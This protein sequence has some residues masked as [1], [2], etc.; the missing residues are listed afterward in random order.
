MIASNKTLV[1]YAKNSGYSERS[2]IIKWF[3]KNKPGKLKIFGKGW[4]RPIFENYFLSRIVNFLFNKFDLKYNFLKKDYM[5]TCNNKLTVLTNFK[6]AFCIENVFNEKGYNTAQIFDIMKA[7]TIPIY[8]GRKDIHKIIPKNCYI[9]YNKFD[10]LDDLYNF[11]KNMSDKKIN[12]YQKNIFKFCN[13]N[14]PKEF[15]EKNFRKTIL[16]QIKQK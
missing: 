2:K 7:S 11:I 15:T 10:K 1:S 9:D 14:F 8:L 16:K 13:K 5:G 4:D 12:H 6:F 3:I